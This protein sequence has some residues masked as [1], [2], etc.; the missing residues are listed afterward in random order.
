M[1]F[2]VLLKNIYQVYLLI[3]YQ[4]KGV[5]INPVDLN[6]NDSTVWSFS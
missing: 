4:T 5:S 1:G 3:G 2:T 6:S